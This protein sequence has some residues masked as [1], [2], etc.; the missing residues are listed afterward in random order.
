V[1]SEADCSHHSGLLLVLSYVAAS[2]LLHV[3]VEQLVVRNKNGTLGID[4]V[5][6]SINIGTGLAVLALCVYAWLVKAETLPHS[7]N[8]YI[9]CGTVL[10]LVGLHVYRSEDEPDSEVTTTP[11]RNSPSTSVA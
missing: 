10:L 11:M 3:C 1:F 5:Y 9:G 8:L 4:C 7:V 6:K 2:T